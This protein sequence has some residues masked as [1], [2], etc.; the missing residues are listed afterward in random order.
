MV[1]GPGLSAQSSWEGGSDERKVDKEKHNILRRS[2]HEI[3][4]TRKEHIMSHGPW[5]VG[6]LED[7]THKCDGAKVGRR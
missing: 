4:K 1:C 6:M 7:N 5:L 2:L 3:Q